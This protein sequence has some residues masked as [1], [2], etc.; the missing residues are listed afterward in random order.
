MDNRKIRA[1]T[2]LFTEDCPLSCRYC[3]LKYED[4]YG[5]YD[6]Q[7]FEGSIS[8]VFRLGKMI[9]ENNKFVGKSC[10]GSY[11]ARRIEF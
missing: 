5:L 11:M 6:G 3:Q 4:E 10:K 7:T 9:V 8:A 1:H 2:I